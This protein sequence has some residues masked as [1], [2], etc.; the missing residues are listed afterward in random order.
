MRIYR[1]SLLG[2]LLAAFIARTTSV[3]ANEQSPD[4]SWH[5]KS[6][7]GQQIRL[8]LAPVSR[9]AL[10]RLHTKEAKPIRPTRGGS[11]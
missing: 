9:P 10:V 2:M 5:T 1:G 7:R 6:R 8:D 4:F 3:L 11:S